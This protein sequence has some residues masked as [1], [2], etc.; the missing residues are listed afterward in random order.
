MSELVVQEKNEIKA[1]LSDSLMDKLVSI[2]AALPKDFNKTRFVQN[3]I[4]VLN[5]KPELAKINQQMLIQGLVK[6]AYLGLDFLADECYLIPYGQSIEFQTSYRGEIKIAKKYSIRPVLDIYAKVVREGDI[7]EEKIIDGEQSINFSP[8]PFNGGDIIGA[9]AVV[10]YKDGG[11]QYEAMS[12]S[13]IN[14]VRS[15]Y[16]K[17]ANGKAW[18]NSF[19]QMC[20]KT[21][22]RRLCKYI[23]ID[24]ESV[25][26]RLAWDE[27]SDLD[28]NRVNKP[29]SDAVVNVFDTVV[30]EDGSIT[31]VP[32]NE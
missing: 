25:E 11:M 6:G 4:A 19:D 1:K 23:E 15:N 7:F 27:S 12:V 16:S 2:E 20:I 14:A 26:A 22:L 3:A 13:D 18:K 10:T 28:K 5:D 24:F 8:L 17:M 29:V 30:E 21:V 32:A 31:E 9:F